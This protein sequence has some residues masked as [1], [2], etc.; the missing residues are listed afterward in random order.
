MNPKKVKDFTEEVAEKLNL[1]KELVED[2]TTF[3]WEQ[4]RENLSKLSATHIQLY[5]FGIFRSR[6]KQIK[7][8]LKKYGDMKVALETSTKYSDK[9]KQDIY[10]EIDDKLNLLGHNFEM[11]LKNY[12]ARQDHWANRFKQEKKNV[13]IKGPLAE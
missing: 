10:K 2:L 11:W 3:F 6:P 8:Q 7:K 12:A 13:E 1:D 9:K 4:V 5:K